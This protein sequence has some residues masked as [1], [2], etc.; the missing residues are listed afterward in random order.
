MGIYND[1]YTAGADLI[2]KMEKILAEEKAKA[3]ILLSAQWHRDELNWITAHNYMDH[4]IFLVE[5]QKM[6]KDDI[7][8]NMKAL[9]EWF[10]KDW[11]EE[12]SENHK[13]MQSFFN[14][15][16]KIRKDFRQLINRYKHEILT[17]KD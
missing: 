4:L 9:E 10:E 11:D 2:L 14:L 16:V 8:Q 1:L 15:Y 3:H 13:K 12:L 5:Q 6:E 7:A 17:R